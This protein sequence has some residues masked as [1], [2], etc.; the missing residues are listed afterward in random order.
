M[1]SDV[2][3]TDGMYQSALAEFLIEGKG[4][5]R[6]S[7]AMTSS[8]ILNRGTFCGENILQNERSKAMACFRN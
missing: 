7:H 2:T 1:T 3:L 4:A 8:E 5:N 6:K